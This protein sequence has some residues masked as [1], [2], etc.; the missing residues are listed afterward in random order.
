MARANLTRLRI[1]PLISEGKRD[2]LGERHGAPQGTALV[3]QA[4]APPQPVA[5]R[6]RQVPEADPVV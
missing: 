6:R 3:K 1:P 4:E 2:V 5:I